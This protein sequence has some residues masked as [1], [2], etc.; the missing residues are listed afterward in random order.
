VGVSRLSG[1]L[2]GGVSSA[3]I[4]ICGGRRLA[5]LLEV[6]G[7]SRCPTWHGA[8]VA[9]LTQTKGFRVEGHRHELSNDVRR[10]PSAISEYS[11]IVFCCAGPS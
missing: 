7:L 5:F 6:V 8:C 1:G 10:S 4:D 11:D 9:I 3:A 2:C